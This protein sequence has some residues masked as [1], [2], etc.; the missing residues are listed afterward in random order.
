MEKKEHS[1][2]HQVKRYGFHKYKREIVAD[3]P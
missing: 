3:T 2:A 1:V